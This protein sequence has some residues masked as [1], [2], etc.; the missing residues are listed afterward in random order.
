MSRW[1]IVRHAETPWNAEG[2]I[3]G[4]TDTPL[5]DR[6]YEQAN[7]LAARLA[8]REIDAAYVSDLLRAQETARVILQGRDIP[9]TPSAQ[10]RERSYGH[11]EGLTFQDV[12]QAYPE[13][14]AKFRHSP[15]APPPGGESTVDMEARMG[16]FA[17]GLRLAHGDSDTLLIVGHGGSL[18]ALIAH[19]LDLPPIAAFRFSL[20]S[21]SLTMLD[22]RGD[23][24]VLRLLGDTSHWDGKL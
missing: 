4:Q 15:D 24:A 2:K 10:L 3:Q 11:W 7:A 18:N 6:G 21:A 8:G 16:E 23:R 5:S 22:W 13:E 17:S 14:F 20:G 9:L 1:L 12:A 19:L